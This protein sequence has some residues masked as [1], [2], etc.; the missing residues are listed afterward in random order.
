[1][2]M[3]IKTSCLHMLN[4]NNFHLSII[5]KKL[6]TSPG[7]EL[8]SAEFRDPIG[9][10]GLNFFHHLACFSLFPTMTLL[11]GK[12]LKAPYSLKSKIQP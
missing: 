10:T 8:G 3:C 9:L 2:D 6:K 4:I 1:M 12:W 11:G 5:F 7:R